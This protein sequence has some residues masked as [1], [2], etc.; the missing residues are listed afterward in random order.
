MGSKTGKDEKATVAFP[1]MTD[2]A[3]FQNMV[4]DIS[5]AIGDDHNSTPEAALAIVL[6]E[7]HFEQF[8]LVAPESVLT[9]LGALDVARMRL[10]EYMADAELMDDDAN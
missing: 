6:K 9:L 1:P 8:V 10:L 4:A 5:D 7:A 2:L 3:Q